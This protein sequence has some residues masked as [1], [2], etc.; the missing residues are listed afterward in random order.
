MTRNFFDRDAARRLKRKRWTLLSGFADHLSPDNEGARRLLIEEARAAPQDPFCT[1]GFRQRYFH[2]GYVV[3]D[4]FLLEPSRFDPRM[5]LD[6]VPFDQGE[7][8]PD[9]A[10]QVRSMPAIPARVWSNPAYREIQERCLGIAREAAGLSW[11][12]PLAWESHLIR[13]VAKP[14]KPAVATPDVIHFDD[15]RNRMNTFII[16]IERD[17]VVGGVNIIT[18]RHCAGLVAK[19]V[20]ADDIHF[21]GVI[22]RPFDG[23]GFIDSDLAHYVSGIGAAPGASMGA[24][25]ILIF[26]FVKLIREP[27]AI[28]A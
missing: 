3:D 12:T 11:T 23:Y 21:K 14:G 27:I 8:N 5:G 24:R 6:V 28:A 9:F 15:D 16:V 17:N 4:Q 1:E 22:E 13:L 25:T 20:P 26:D 10:G 19:D 7:A 2:K 18:K